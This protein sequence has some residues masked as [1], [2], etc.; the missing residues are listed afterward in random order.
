MGE[1]KMKHLLIK[2]TNKNDETMCLDIA[3]QAKT[4]AVD[5]IYNLVAKC[6]F[7]RSQGFY[8][9]TPDYGYPVKCPSCK[10]TIA[11]SDI[12]NSHAYCERCN[13]SYLSKEIV[14]A[15]KLNPTP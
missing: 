1:N 5:F 3:I 4:L 10:Q 15:K 9:I 12:E 7:L 2:G 6:N 8:L 13:K 14:K 11:V